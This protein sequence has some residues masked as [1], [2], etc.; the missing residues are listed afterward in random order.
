MGD[1][2]AEVSETSFSSFCE[3][4]EVK[5]II[6][7][8]TCCKNP[9]NPSCIDLFLTNSINSFQKSTVVETG[10]SDFHRL[11]V[12]VIKSYSPKRTPDIVPYRKYTNFDMDKFIEEIS[13]NLAKHN[14]QELTREAFISMFNTVFEKHAPLK[15]KYLRSGHSKFVTKERSR[16]IML[17]PKLRKKFLKDRTEE[18]RCKCKK[19]RNVCVYLFK[20]AKKEYY[21]NIDISN[22][23]NSNLFWKKVKPI[24]GSKIKSKNSITLIEGTKIIQEEG[25]FGKTLND[26]FAS[27]VENLG[28]TENLLPTSSSETRNVE[29]II[30]KFENHPSVVTIRNCFDDNSIFSFKEIGETELIKQ[31][32]HLDIKNRS[33]SSDIPTK[34]IKEFADLF[35]TFITENFNLCLNK[36]EFPKILKIAEVTPI[37]KNANPFDKDIY[38]PISILSNISKKI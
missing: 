37:Y 4:S 16:A 24:F 27:I 31:I 23:T 13:F 30:A 36:G 5:G 34:I 8:S 32:N 15:K 22:L 9:T 2:N 19:Q 25:E 29:S 11:I 38:R 10:L 17:R 26:F 7:Q 33:L 1:F 12:S 18:S 28:I 21:E 35:A 14:L 20:K 3:L 6:N